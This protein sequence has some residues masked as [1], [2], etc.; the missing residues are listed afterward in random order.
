METKKIDRKKL[1][2]T[3]LLSASL[4]VGALVGHSFYNEDQATGSYNL[5][6]VYVFNNGHITGIK[7]PNS[8][9]NCRNA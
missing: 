4:T 9:D 5:S 2:K 7:C 8:G 3:A 1:A 6:A